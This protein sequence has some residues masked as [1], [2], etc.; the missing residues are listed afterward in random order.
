M[1]KQYRSTNSTDRSTAD[2][3]RESAGASHDVPVSDSGST[4]VPPRR[5]WKNRAPSQAAA[6]SVTSGDV[7]GST[8]FFAAAAAVAAPASPVET[9]TAVVI[10]LKVRL[11]NLLRGIESE[12]KADAHHA[13]RIELTDDWCP[14]DIDNSK[15]DRKRAIKHNRFHNTMRGNVGTHAARGN[16][17]YEDTENRSRMFAILKYAKSC[18]HVLSDGAQLLLNYLGSGK[19]GNYRLSDEIKASVDSLN[20][21]LDRCIRT[22]VNDGCHNDHG[23][24]IFRSACQVAAYTWNEFRV[25]IEPDPIVLEETMIRTEELERLR[26]EAEATAREDAIQRQIE[27]KAAKIRDALIE[28]AGDDD[29]D[30]ETKVTNDDLAEARLQYDEEQRQTE[31][32]RRLAEEAR[33]EAEQE[34]KRVTEVARL[35]ELEVARQKAEVKLAQDVIKI[36]KEYFTSRR[37]LEQLREEEREISAR[38]R[39]II[40]SGKSNIQESKSLCDRYTTNQ[41]AIFLEVGCALRTLLE[42]EHIHRQAKK[43]WRDSAI[44]RNIEA[45]YEWIN[46]IRFREHRRLPDDREERERELERRSLKQSSSSGS[47]Q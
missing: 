7:T 26:L 20:T 3:I 22:G 30:V 15:A 23:N 24:T 5:G 41:N 47:S 36:E 25:T 43:T 32:A 18:G 13:A 14:D 44:L 46:P 19:A 12:A 11:D 1:S 27:K 31:E 42:A 2:S 40:D 39:E 16:T 10:P 21:A 28:A 17:L 37:L 29:W 8:P 4:G 45:E 9:L 38:R 6:T 35:E 33:R 34:A